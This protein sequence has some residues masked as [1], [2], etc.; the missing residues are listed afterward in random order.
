MINNKFIPYAKIPIISFN[1][2]NI[3]IKKRLSQKF[4]QNPQ[5]NTFKNPSSFILSKDSFKSYLLPFKRKRYL[6]KKSSGAFLKLVKGLPI[7]KI[8]NCTNPINPK[9][10]ISS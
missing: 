6:I 3:G 4:R 1:S 8:Q 2:M 7:K 10:A 5:I 9:I